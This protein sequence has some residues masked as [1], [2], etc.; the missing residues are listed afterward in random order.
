MPSVSR[1]FT[2]TSPPDAVYAYLADFANAEEWDPG[3]VECS[4]TSGDG[5]V[6]TTYRNVSSFLGRKTTLEYTAEELNAPSSVH[7]VGRNEQFE[8]HDRLRFEASGAGTQVTYDAEFLFKGAS[9]LAAPLVS[10]YL[11]SLATKTVAQLR[12]SL[13]NLSSAQH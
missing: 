10:L 5:G 4:R 9:K 6:G 8:G 13:D 1:T 2:T 11:P 7:F 12:R 3:T